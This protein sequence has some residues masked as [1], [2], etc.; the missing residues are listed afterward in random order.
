MGFDFS[1]WLSI[2][3]LHGVA[4]ASPGPD[5]AVVMKQSLQQ[6]RRAGM[7][8][9][10]GIGCGIFLHVTYSIL[11][12]SILIMATPWLYHTLMYGAAIYFIWMGVGAI[13]SAPTSPTNAQTHH[14]TLH[15]WRKAFVIGFVTNGLNPKATLFFLTLFTLA[16]PANTSIFVQ[17][18]YGVYLAIASSLWFIL[19]SMLV[20]H[21]RIRRAYLSHGYIFDRLMGGVLIIM[22]I[23]LVVTQ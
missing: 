21:S 11:G 5:F 18:V 8:T 23:L 19:V 9:S 4:V 7:I 1:V 2:A 20:S 10:F 17:C 12:V 14:F 22:A 16:V 6:G 13:R 15:S 3:L